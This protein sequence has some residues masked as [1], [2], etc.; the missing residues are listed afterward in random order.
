MAQDVIALLFAGDS[1]ALLPN[2][3]EGARRFQQSGGTPPEDIVVAHS[4]EGLLVTLVWGEGVD[5]ET[6]G[7]HMLGLLGELGLP[8]PRISHGTLETSS[9]TALT[10][11]T[12]V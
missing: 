9:W 3:A 2:Y 5:H 8:F 1:K 6:F 12:R 4:P 7:R 11:S 10:S